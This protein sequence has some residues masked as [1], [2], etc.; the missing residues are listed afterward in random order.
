MSLN[1][2]TKLDTPYSTNSTVRG[3][4][5][6]LDDFVKLF[7]LTD[8][9]FLGAGCDAVVFKVIYKG[10]VKALKL[11]GSSY[12][13]SYNKYIDRH[14]QEIG[15]NNLTDLT[16]IYIGC[17]LSST[18]EF[19]S[20]LIIPEASGVFDIEVMNLVLPYIKDSEDIISGSE[21]LV[22][23][24][25]P[26]LNNDWTIPLSLQDRIEILFEI[27]IAIRSL[28]QIGIYHNDI[29]NQNILYEITSSYRQYQV[30]GNVYLVKCKYKPVILDFGRSTEHR[31]L[32][33]FLDDY[34]NLR[35]TIFI[36]RLSDDIR[37]KIL[38]D[39]ANPLLSSVF[40]LLTEGTFG[41]DTEVQI[42][43]PIEVD[44]LNNPFVECENN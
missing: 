32:Y 25:Y 27:L 1:Y 13:E 2:I 19:T 40:D 6:S 18:R 29:H 33:D 30:N 10:E 12:S 20:S 15:P 17:K 22:G 7:D 4:L 24:V 5:I 38:Y 34:A 37:R 28:Y 21:C 39:D 8:V 44:G 31:E 11:I 26:I 9:K 3:K 23:I 42:F 41:E 43:S 16:D 14:F 36:L 35:K